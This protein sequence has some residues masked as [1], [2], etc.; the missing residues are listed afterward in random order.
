ME[1]KTFLI[2]VTNDPNMPVKHWESNRNIKFRGGP[3]PILQFALEM[4][5]TLCAR[6]VSLEVLVSRISI[7][8]TVEL[9][10]FFIPNVLLILGS[11]GTKIGNEF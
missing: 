5:I 4:I 8:T 1:Q 9:C 10:I 3:M 11:S 2:F 6:L 7:K